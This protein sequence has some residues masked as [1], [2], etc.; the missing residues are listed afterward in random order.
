MGHILPEAHRDFIMTTMLGCTTGVNRLARP[1]ACTGATL[2]HKTGT[3]DRNAEGRLMALN[4]AGFV[5]PPDGRHYTIAVFIK[6]SQASDAE[7]EAML[8]GISARV[9]R[10]VAGAAALPE[11][12]R[13]PDHP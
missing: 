9:Y 7:T 12:R 13:E 2:A 1:L 4:D 6:D 5:L 3:S 8:A 11:A 10:H